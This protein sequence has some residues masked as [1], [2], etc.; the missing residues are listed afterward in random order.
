MRK[1]KHIVISADDRDRLLTLIHSARLDSRV[2]VESLDAL[3]GE[4]SR[5]TI[6]SAD[7]VPADVI[8]MNSMV[9]F[10]DLDSE[11]VETYT[12]VYPNEADV[13]RDRISV[14]APIGTALL[15]YR[16]GDTIEW[17]VP[18]GKRRIQITKVSPCDASLKVFA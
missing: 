18:A 10:Q 3:E 13:I 5:A 4:L 9:W 12:L 1:H 8:A 17:T 15:G 16:V 11:E 7:D 14:L 2:P 6:V